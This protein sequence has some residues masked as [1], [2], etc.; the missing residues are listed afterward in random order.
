MYFFKTHK[1]VA[2]AVL[3]LIVGTI[4]VSTYVYV[5]KKKEKELPTASSGVVEIVLTSA[6][7]QPAEITISTGTKVVFSADTAKQHWPAS[8]LHPTHMLYSEFDAQH[9][10]EPDETWSFVFDKKGRW[11]FHDHL[12]A[13][14]SGTIYVVDK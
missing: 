9:P 14:Y 1:V 6:G 4:C 10:L 11:D 12:R 13:Y 2:S 8:N 7:Y 3:T 5:S